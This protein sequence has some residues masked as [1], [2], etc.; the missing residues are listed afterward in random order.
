MNDDTERHVFIYL[1]EVEW[2][3]ALKPKYLNRGALV[4]TDNTEKQFPVDSHELECSDTLEFPV[5]PHELDISDFFDTP[6]SV[7]T[8][9]D[10]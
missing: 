4:A 8:T 1:L 10:N 3:E 2:K 9:C 5:H 6:K 7:S